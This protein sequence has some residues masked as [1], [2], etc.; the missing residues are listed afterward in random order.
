MSWFGFCN[1]SVIVNCV[2][3]SLKHILSREGCKKCFFGVQSTLRLRPNQVQRIGAILILLQFRSIL[4]YL[5]IDIS[6]FNSI[7]HLK[8]NDSCEIRFIIA[9]RRRLTTAL[10]L[11]QIWTW[12]TGWPLTRHVYWTIDINLMADVLLVPTDTSSRNAQESKNSK[13]SFTGFN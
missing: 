10:L 6:R 2:T 8:W 3:Y 4:R 1:L 7:S 12:I 13:C 5:Y 11:S 9:Y